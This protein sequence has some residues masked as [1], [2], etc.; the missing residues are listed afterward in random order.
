V[1]LLPTLLKNA[2]NSSSN[3]S[4]CWKEQYMNLQ[5]AAKRTRL[6]NQSIKSKCWK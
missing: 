3:L 1:V 2:E 6:G 5:Y 4:T